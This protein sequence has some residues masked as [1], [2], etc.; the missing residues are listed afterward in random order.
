M[1]TGWRYQSPRR[2]EGS[3]LMFLHNKRM[4]Y[5]VSVD[6]PIPAFAKMLLK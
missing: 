4:M 3:Q 5:K 1:H 2:T 6:E